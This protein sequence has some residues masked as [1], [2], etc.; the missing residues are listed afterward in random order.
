[1][2]IVTSNLWVKSQIFTLESF[3]TQVTVKNSKVEIPT[4][5]STAARC[6]Q[7]NGTYC[8]TLRCCTI[9]S[10]EV[11]N[12]FVL[13]VFKVVLYLAPQSWLSLVY[14]Y[15]TCRMQIGEVLV[16]NFSP[17]T[18]MLY[19]VLDPGRPEHFN[20]IGLAKVAR[21]HGVDS[22]KFIFKWPNCIMVVMEL[23]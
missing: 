14:G 18:D 20:L 1:M 10:L 4:P 8:P 23:F 16:Y 3:R 5:T 9:H 6:F 12:V 17:C 15:S 21:C 11:V 2:W 13:I 7:T 22:W 19:T